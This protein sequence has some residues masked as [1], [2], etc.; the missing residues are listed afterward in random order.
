M[1]K[2]EILN[3]TSTK[4]L[5]ELCKFPMTAKLKLVYRASLHGFTALAFHKKCDHLQKVV[6]LIKSD[7]SNIFGGYSSKG[8]ILFITALIME[9]PNL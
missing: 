1:S 7:S 8:N 9:L 6:I 3:I 5:L 4:K 2:S